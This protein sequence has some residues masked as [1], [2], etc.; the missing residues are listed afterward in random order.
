MSEDDYGA[1]IRA[2]QAYA[3][4]D[5]VALAQALAISVRTLE[6]IYSNERALTLSEAKKIA[7]VCE[8]P[9]GFIVEGWNTNRPIQD[10]LSE[11][12][13]RIADLAETNGELTQHER[14]LLGRFEEMVQRLGRDIGRGQP[15]S[16]GEKDLP[17]AAGS[18]G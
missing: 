5:Q 15:R 7:E 11:I 9:I 13:R 4:L 8:V 12:D 2:A 14:E 1:R 3:G 17:R 6:R 18:R 16:R 10:R